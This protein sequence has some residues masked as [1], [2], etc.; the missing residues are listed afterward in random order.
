M[1]SRSMRLAAGFGAVV[2]SL[3][4][5]QAEAR[6]D[7]LM[8]PVE[9]VLTEYA[10]RLDSDVKFYFGKQSYP[11]PSKKLGEYV[12]NKKT[13]AFNKSDEEAC[14]WVMLSA[15]LQLQERAQSEGGNAV[16]DIRSYYK[17]NEVSSETEY[18]CHAGN[19]MAGVALI[20]R[21]VK[22]D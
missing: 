10:D 6:D 12:T 19:I 5:F 16:V 1:A 7:G 13:N 17:K 15:L 2:L 14:R 11:T 20:G 18:E 9:D 22:I 3:A 21:V 4:G 8:L